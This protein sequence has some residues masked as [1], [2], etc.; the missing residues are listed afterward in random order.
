MSQGRAVSERSPVLCELGV[1]LRPLRSKASKD[2][3]R[4]CKK[5]L[6]SIGVKAKD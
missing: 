3:P 1:S 2:L 6:T 4:C 5:P